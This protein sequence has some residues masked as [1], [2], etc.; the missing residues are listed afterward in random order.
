MAAPKPTKVY[1]W[2]S[3]SAADIVEPTSGEIAQGWLPG[4][5]PPGEYMN[6][7]MGGDFGTAPWLAYVRDFEQIV[8][9]WPARQN[10]KDGIS[11]GPGG[12]RSTIAGLDVTSG[13][14][15]DKLTPAAGT[16]VLGAPLIDFPLPTGR[17]LTAR[18]IVN[19]SPLR[20]GRAY[21]TPTG[22]EFSL[23][24]GWDTAN[25]R[26]VADS[27]ASPAVLF[28]LT[29]ASIRVCR[30]AAPS[31]TF[32][33]SAFTEILVADSTA[34][35][36]GQALGYPDATGL[37]TFSSAIRS[38]SVL[39]GTTTFPFLNPMWTVATAT[40]WSDVTG[41]G[42][43]IGSITSNNNAAVQGQS[44]IS[45]AT[46]PPGLT[47][48]SGSETYGVGW[49]APAGGTPSACR[50]DIDTSGTLYVRNT[51]ANALVSTATILLPCLRWRL[52]SG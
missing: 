45:V 44:S 20:Y 40:T 4:T 25:A 36:R 35:A 10:F 42:N 6:A 29:G 24:A 23:N 15:A 3:G 9:D 7:L 32:L 46:L 16:G 41:C 13:L 8:R 43:L 52:Q 2:A 5:T 1:A 14:T 26:W 37:A 21:V 12:Q 34:G 38:A 28:R 49:Y 27:T 31:A 11:T 30:V 47:P 19:A 39:A 18:H 17:Y 51:A 33:D 50:V 48:V 22:F